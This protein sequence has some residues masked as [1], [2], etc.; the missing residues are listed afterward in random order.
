MVYVLTSFFTFGKTAPIPRRR[1]LY[2]MIFKAL[3]F[4]SQLANRN[5]KRTVGARV[6]KCHVNTRD[7]IR[8]D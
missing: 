4:S 8:L 3:R 5:T 6:V 7:L 1:W 2:T